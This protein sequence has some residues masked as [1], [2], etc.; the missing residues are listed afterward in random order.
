LIIGGDIHLNIQQAAM[1]DQQTGE[2]IEH[3]S[4]L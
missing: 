1:P 4:T 3:G 2:V